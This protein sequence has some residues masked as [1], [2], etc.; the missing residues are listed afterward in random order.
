MSKPHR[1]AATLALMAILAAMTAVANAQTAS[2]AASGAPTQQQEEAAK[3]TTANTIADQRLKAKLQAISDQTDELKA[4]YDLLLEQQKAKM[5]EITTELDRLSTA[6]KLQDEQSKLQLSARNTDLNRMSLENKLSDELIKSSMTVLSQQLSRLKMENDLATEQQRALTMD[7]AKERDS[8]DL[9]LKRMDLAERKLR[10]EK[11]VMDSRVDRIKSDL[12]LR[13][14]KEEWKKETNT[15][16]R[17]LSEPFRD[18][19]L[20]ISDRRIQLN[21]PIYSGIASYVTDRIHYYNNI[22]S[23]PVFLVI[24]SSP[25]GSV[26]E[27]YRIIKAMQAS[28]APVYVVVK[29]FAAS[30][31]AVITTMAEKSYVYPNAIVLHHQMSTV[32]W[33]NMTQLKEQLE[34][35]K[36][37]ERRLHVP[38]AKRMGVSLEQF[39][40]M[41][42]EKNSNGDWE[43]FGDKAVGYKWAT[44]VVDEIEETG[45]V[46]NPDDQT[47]TPKHIEAES[48]VK[49]TEKLDENGMRYVALPRLDPCDFYFIYN[50]DRYY[51]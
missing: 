39:R 43:E 2:S 50:P 11:L 37:W 35:S 10:F 9:E 36:E 23:A 42:Y 51:R 30:M 19:H 45:I 17:Y 47:V 4:K 22:S 6:N 7:S 44:A 3:L 33:G 5:A 1:T 34:L 38:V 14:K 27:G 13:D 48:S 18:G 15:E 49:L 20:V 32:A 16:P 31:A 46:K 29:S 21:G 41:M 8:I 28:K 26:M 25:G 40:K 24:D 12:D